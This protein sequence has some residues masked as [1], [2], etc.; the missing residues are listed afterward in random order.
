[1]ASIEA[2]PEIVLFGASMTE[3]SFKEKTQGVGWFL[4]NQYAGKAKI[5]NEGTATRFCSAIACVCEGLPR[6]PY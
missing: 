4:E 3:W 6:K 2:L 1:M 5:L